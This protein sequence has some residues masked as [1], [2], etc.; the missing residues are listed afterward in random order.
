MPKYVK[1]LLV[2]CVLLWVW[3]VYLLFL[4]ILPN[5]YGEIFLFLGVLF[6]SLGLTFSFIFYFIYVKKYPS[7]T[8]MRVLFRRSLKWGFFISFGF[9]GLGFLKALN[10]ISLLNAG[11]F[12]LLYAAT[13]IQ[14]RGRR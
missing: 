11:L 12:G 2:L 5:S 7:F 14:L 10:I 13:F 6:F 1:S 8:D 9:I 3:W 4:G